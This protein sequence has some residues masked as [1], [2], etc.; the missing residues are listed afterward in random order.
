M[1]MKLD[2]V[3]VLAPRPH[4]TTR[5]AFVFASAAGC[6]AFAAGYGAGWIVHRP[7]AASPLPTVDPRHARALGLAAASTP[8][9][10][11]LDHQLFLIGIVHEQEI[12]GYAPD[13]LWRAIHR[14][15]AVVVADA[16]LPDRRLR[17]RTILD[18][19]A[20]RRPADPDFTGLVPAL[21]LAVRR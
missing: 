4:V 3:F 20:R 17:A 2:P 13:L 7:S 5:R 12:D 15:A 9:G 10:T 21:E 8:I 1:P 18:L 16:T 6:F 19:L 11:L 14:I